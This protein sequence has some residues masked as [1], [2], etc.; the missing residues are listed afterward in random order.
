[1]KALIGLSTP[2]AY[3]Y[4]YQIQDSRPNPLLDTPMGLFLFFEEIWFIDRKLCPYNM[5]NLPYVFFLNEEFN[6]EEIIVE[7]ILKP[8]RINDP[9]SSFP[10]IKNLTNEVRQIAHDEWLKAYDLNSGGLEGFDNHSRGIKIG[11]SHKQGNASEDNLIIDTFLAKQYDLELITNTRTSYLASISIENELKRQLSDS[12]I[13]ENI[14]S[15]QFPEGPYHE[16]IEDLRSHHLLLNYRNK[17]SRTVKGKELKD[18]Q[19]MKLEIINQIKEYIDEV[20]E[21]H[22]SSK[23]IVKSVVDGSV[24][25]IPLLSNLYSV[26]DSATNISKALEEKRD[27]GWIGFATKAKKYQ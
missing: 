23:K 21:S 18:L 22:F 27:Y 8:Y 7:E 15:F 1:M 16:F 19:S 20:M 5:E 11:K 14:S 13:C 24:G 12:I 6:L 26:V 10:V 25:Q 9:D 4:K 17:I 3:N 2:L